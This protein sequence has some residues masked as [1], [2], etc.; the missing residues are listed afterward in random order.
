M[1]ESKRAA[2]CESDKMDTLKPPENLKL[3]G[4]V[5]SNWQRSLKQQFE[6]YMAAIGV[7]EAPEP[8]KVALLLTIAGPQAIEVYN[9]FVFG[10]NEDKNNL[11][12]VLAKFPAHCSPKKKQSSLCKGQSIF[13]KLVNLLNFMSKRLVR[14]CK[15]ACFQMQMPQSVQYLAKESGASPEM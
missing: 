6:L 15:W 13:V 1:S 3:T 12:D 8:R 9:T 5:D 14:W 7:D 4:N 10:V 11:D 2:S